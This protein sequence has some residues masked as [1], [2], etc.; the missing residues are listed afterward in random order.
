MRTGGVKE[1]EDDVDRGRQDGRKEAAAVAARETMQ[2]RGGDHRLAKRRRGDTAAVGETKEATRKG[3]GD[4][5][6]Y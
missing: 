6:G 4:G 3:R 2:I 5:E 1:E